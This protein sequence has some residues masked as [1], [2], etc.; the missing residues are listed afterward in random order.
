[1]MEVL[2]QVMRQYQIILHLI[3]ASVNIENSVKDNDS[4]SVLKESHSLVMTGATGTIV[5]DLQVL[6]F[7]QNNIY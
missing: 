3:K 6:L 2:L 7:N 4:Y 1:M 5:A